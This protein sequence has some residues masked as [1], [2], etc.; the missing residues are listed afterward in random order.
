MYPYLT[1]FAVISLFAG[2]AFVAFTNYLSIHS[3]IRAFLREFLYMF[4]TT[5][6]IIGL[7]FRL[8]FIPTGSMEPETIK[9]GDKVV[10]WKMAYGARIPET[11]LQIPFAE[12][13]YYK[14]LKLPYLRLPGYTKPKQND[15]FIFNSPYEVVEHN[16]DMAQPFVKRLRVGPL[17]TFKRING[18]IFIKQKDGSFLLQMLPAHAILNQKYLIELK[19]FR[20]MN[21]AISHLKKL[22]AYEVTTI[23]EN[24]FLITT[25]KAVARKLKH[26]KTEV[27]SIEPYYVPPVRS[28]RVTFKDTLRDK[29]TQMSYFG[30]EQLKVYTWEKNNTYSVQA[31]KAQFEAL[32]QS[33]YIENIVTIAKKT[34]YFDYEQEGDRHLSFVECIGGNEDQLPEI[35]V[36]GKTLTIPINK[37]TLNI[38]GHVIK[39]HDNAHN[40]DKIEIDPVEGTLT[41]NGK[42]QDHYTF[43]Q[44]YYWGEGDNQ[45]HS[46]DSRSWGF[47][48]HNLVIGKATLVVAS[49]KN[50]Y[51]LIDLLTF[52]IRWNRI[53]KPINTDTISAM[54]LQLLLLL[55]ILLSIGLFV[56]RRRRKHDA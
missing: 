27:E 23:G 19:G 11:L 36:P 51:F 45:P 1:L 26:N 7:I 38:Y 24:T 31:N 18:R 54:H 5:Y 14:G 39:W 28:F 34:R 30:V 6:V 56:M 16:R 48:P 2:L 42:K 41:I 13:K 21:K 10:I 4:T 44:D 25:T 17:Q 15:I 49:N 53:L 40:N 47:V 43:K 29:A 37:E 20:F 35:T 55:V 9:V 22:G 8:S 12:K 32:K 52:R 3:N 50:S 46:A 33:P